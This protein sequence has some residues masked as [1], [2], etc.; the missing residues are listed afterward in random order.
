MSKQKDEWEAFLC[1]AS[2]EYLAALNREPTKWSAPEDRKEELL[3]HM[4]G[5]LLDVVHKAYLRGWESDPIPEDRK[6]PEDNFLFDT[7][8]EII[9]V[10]HALVD[11]V[12]RLEKYEQAQEKR[13]RT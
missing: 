4:Q 11:I 12:G 7:H 13:R 3:S 9:E 5:E 10:V 1:D 6:E 2:R 8:G